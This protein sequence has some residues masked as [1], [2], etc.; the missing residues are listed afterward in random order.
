M[1]RANKYDSYVPGY[2]AVPTCGSTFIS[3]E[4]HRHLS[5]TDTNVHI[6]HSERSALNADRK[7]SFAKESTVGIDIRSSRLASSKVHPFL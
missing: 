2:H 6:Q 7:R 5:N 3:S 1:V 4:L